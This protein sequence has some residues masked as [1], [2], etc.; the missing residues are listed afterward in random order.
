MKL[1]SWLSHLDPELKNAKNEAEHLRRIATALASGKSLKEMSDVVLSECALAFG[2]NSSCLYLVV[3]NGNFELRAESGLKEKYGHTPPERV[4]Y[5]QGKG[6]LYLGSSAELVASRPTLASVF[7]LFQSRM[8]AFA[9]FTVDSRIIG[10]YCGVYD[11]QIQSRSYLK[12]YAGAIVQLC[13]L[14]LERFQRIE[15]E[16]AAR[17]RAEAANRAKSEFLAN[18]SHEIRTPIGVVQGFT[19]LLLESEG[20]SPTQRHWVSV[21]S[22]NTEQLSA[23]LGEVLDISKIEAE[24]IEVVLR[25]FSLLELFEDVRTSANYK[26]QDKKIDLIFKTENLPAFVR[27]DPTRLRQILVNLVGN[28]IKFTERGSVEVHAR[29]HG[30]PANRLEVSVKDTGVGI[31]EEAKNAIFEPFIQGPKEAAKVRGTGLGLTICKRLAL[32]LGGDVTLCTSKEGKGS[33]FN[34]SIPCEAVGW[35]KEIAPQLFS[36][37]KNLLTSRRILLVEDSIDTQELI[38][39]LLTREGAEID[40]ADSGV[41]GIKMALGG[42]YD[43]ILMDIQMP[44]LSGSEAMIWLRSQGY[45]RPVVALTAQALSGERQKLLSEGFDDCLTKPIDGVALVHC[46]RRFTARENPSPT[47]H[48]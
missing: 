43:V 18:L 41:S 46:L 15:K 34:L 31:P 37:N 23:L 39:I 48:H 36:K 27:S 10:F 21:I 9:S 11:R 14:A 3:D 1:G 22:R 8:V 38:R 20:L 7:G 17:Q 12:S 4:G 24:K 29:H 42:K 5:P 6:N 35:S 30:E 25:E 2:T 28:A 26:A 44:G 33:T 47:L 16:Q 13:A 45:T 32:A 19:N 40:V